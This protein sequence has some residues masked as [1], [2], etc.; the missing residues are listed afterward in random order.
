MMTHHF[1]LPSQELQR[2]IR[3]L[4]QFG[5]TV[6]IAALKD[7]VQFRFV[8]HTNIYMKSSNNQLM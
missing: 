7:S 5:D 2:I 4:T 8:K 1:Q 6:T 3:D